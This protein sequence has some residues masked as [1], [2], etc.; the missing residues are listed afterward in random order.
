MAA[1]TKLPDLPSALIRVAL[2]DLAK[3]EAMPE[4]YEIN[5]GDWHFPIGG[6]CSVCLA[7]SVMAMSLGAPPDQEFEPR[8][9]SAGCEATYFKLKALDWFRTGKVQTGLMSIDID[10]SYV[11]DRSIAVYGWQPELFRSDME[12]LASDLEAAGL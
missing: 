1:E 6:R 12:Q 2:A 3:V 8:D 10:H 5:M 4:K 11:K 7:G 9:F